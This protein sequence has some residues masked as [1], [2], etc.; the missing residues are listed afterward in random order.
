MEQTAD[1]DAPV[2]PAPV[3]PADTEMTED[4][5]GSPIVNEVEEEET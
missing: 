5:P 1:Q 3:Q 4:P 2:Q